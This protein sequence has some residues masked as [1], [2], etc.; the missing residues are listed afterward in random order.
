[1]NALHRYLP[2]SG[3]YLA[4]FAT[5]LL[6]TESRKVTSKLVLNDPTLPFLNIYLREMKTCIYKKDWYMNAYSSFIQESLKL[7]TTQLS[8]K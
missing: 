4:D 6:L 5:Y 7:E 8:I 2:T 3:K 1:M